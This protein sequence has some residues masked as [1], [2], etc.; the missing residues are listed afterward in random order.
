[1]EMVLGIGISFAPLL[2]LFN[3]ILYLTGASLAAW[4]LNRNI[5]SQNELAQND[6]GRSDD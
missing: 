2:L 3:S 5:D 4:A 1:M 6:I